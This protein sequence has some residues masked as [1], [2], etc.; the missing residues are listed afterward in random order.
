MIAG[1]CYKKSKRGLF[2]KKSREDLRMERYSRTLAYIASEDDY[3]TDLMIETLKSI[4]KER[5]EAM[6]AAAGDI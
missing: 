6:M 4:I 2:R 3:E 1:R 5:D